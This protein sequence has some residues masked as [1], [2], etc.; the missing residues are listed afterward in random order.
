MSQR[1]R[2]GKT[3]APQ[4]PSPPPLTPGVRARIAAA[5]LL[6][7]T[8]EERRTFDEALARSDAFSGLS[9]PD[10]GFARAMASAALRHLG[11]IDSALAPFLQRPL[12]TA[13]PGARALLRIGGAQL[14]V[15]GT[16]DHAAVSETVAAAGRLPGTANAAGFLNAV[17]RKAARAVAA[18]EATPALSAWPAWLRGAMI[19]SLGRDAS[20][21]YARA[22]LEVPALDVTGAPDDI[23]DIAA[24]TDGRV[25]APETVRMEGAGSPEDLPGYEA[26]QWWVQDRAAQVP[27]QLFGDV[28]GRTVLDL[29]AA[30]GG[31]TLQLAARGAQ[32][33]A[34]DRS[35]SRLKRL[36]ANAR[37]TGLAERIRV[38]EANAESW[39]PEAQVDH[40][41]LDAPCS[42]LGTLRRHPEGA[43]IKS[44]DDVAGFPTVQSR[45]L[46]AAAEMLSPGGTLVYCVCSPIR[47]E[48]VDVVEAALAEGLFARA[49]IDAGAAGLP[50]HWATSEGD[51][52]T[53][54]DPDLPDGL[55]D[56][57]HISR[58]RRV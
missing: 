37:R 57:F 27:A 6:M 16:S 4:T 12:D 49:P 25:L 22:A 45:L 24:L 54:P 52:L 40:I 47:A 31:K 29:C 50:R 18:F 41:L 43:W 58:L 1:D 14:F 35:R 5:D 46:A 19:D 51:L 23:E 11:R 2:P 8:L 26:G 53:L 10:R 39:S 42:A 15:L 32:V 30:P 36:K 21:A 9:G 3:R 28:A 13:T 48:G 34:L 17:L 55:N 38:V 56:A 44:V 20:E 33:V 7:R